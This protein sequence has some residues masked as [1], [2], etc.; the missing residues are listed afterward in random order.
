MPKNTNSRKLGVNMS[1]VW[2]V[3]AVVGQLTR[4]AKMAT[5]MAKQTAERAGM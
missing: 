1:V 4:Q 5:A 3:S 2:S